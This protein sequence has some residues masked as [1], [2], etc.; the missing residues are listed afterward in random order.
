MIESNPETGTDTDTG[1]GNDHPTDRKD[2]RIPD[3]DRAI[4][5][6]RGWRPAGPAKGLHSQGKAV[7]VDP[8]EDH[9]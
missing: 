2:V 9:T 1:P 7:S 4:R 6:N 5:R 3:F 8:G